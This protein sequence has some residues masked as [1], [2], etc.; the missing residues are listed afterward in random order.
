MSAENDDELLESSTGLCVQICKFT[1][2]EEY[3]AIVRNAGHSMADFAKMLLKFLD[4]KAPN[5][6]VP[7]L[8]RYAIELAI[9][10]MESYDP[11]ISFFKAA[12]LEKVLT[13]VAETSSD[14]ENFHLF[15]GDVGV[16]KHPQ[17]ISSLVLRAKR[18]LL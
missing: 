9:W 10:M 8:R 11:F 4:N 3:D 12:K 16:A 6:T 15:S 18:L 17:S 1:S 14:I 5:K 2:I 13:Q 7:C